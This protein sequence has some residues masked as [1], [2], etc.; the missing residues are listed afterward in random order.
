[1]PRQRVDAPLSDEHELFDVA[2]HPT[3]ATRELV[4]R[5]FADGGP[6][7]R[8]YLRFGIRY[9]SAPG[10]LTDREGALFID[11][12]AELTTILPAMHR[13]SNGRPALARFRGFFR[14]FMNLGAFQRIDPS[15]ELPA[16]ASALR[17]RL[18]SPIQTGASSIE[19]ATHSFLTAYETVMATNIVAG[20]AAEKLT[21][22]LGSAHARVATILASPPRDVLIP[23]DD[24][25]PPRGIVG[26]TL[27]LAD[28]SAFV[29]TAPERR[30]DA[31]TEV[32]WR[33]RS[34]AQRAALAHHIAHASRALR[35]RE[36][37]RWLVISSLTPLREALRAAAA[38]Q[39]IPSTLTWFTSISS[40]AQPPVDVDVLMRAAR[41]HDVVTPTT[42]H[43]QTSPSH[44]VEGI[45]VS[46]GIAEG[47]LATPE[48]LTT[49]DAPRI[50]LAPMLSADLVSFLDDV[51]GIVAGRGGI[52][53]HAAIVAR[54]RH[55]PI[56]V[57]PAAIDGTLAPG[58]RVR[59][60]GKTGSIIVQT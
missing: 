14:T 13:G 44:S 12:N 58:Q 49:T 51:I 8:A 32:W 60:D 39:S 37:G 23:T 38:S 52:L 47:S 34:D 20:S 45:G 57:A 28:T 40:W 30:E 36:I 11:R 43:V 50:L 22:A 41:A 42:P 3:P 24:I 10:L 46:P 19:D 2:P 54:E 59:I 4:T 31:E 6:V 53:A 56:V 15:H 29:A 1:M 25:A 17:A 21:T 18:S 5:I 9:E 26:N 7:A 35:L 33:G 27:E 55:I 48:R 16:L